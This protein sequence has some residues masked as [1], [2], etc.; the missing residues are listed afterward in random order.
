[1]KDIL[2]TTSSNSSIVEKLLPF[3]RDV[4]ALLKQLRNEILFYTDLLRSIVSQEKESI[5]QLL[6]DLTTT[7]R[8]YSPD[9]VRVVPSQE[10]LQSNPL[11][12]A[13]VQAQTAMAEKV[14]QS[15]QNK[16]KLI[17]VL[18]SECKTVL[19]ALS[20][21]VDAQQKKELKDLLTNGSNAVPI[22][23]NESRVMLGEFFRR[24]KDRKML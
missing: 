3:H 11:N 22:K 16:K 6:A 18:P 20:P 4:E 14:V 2:I 8:Q 23:F 1:M 12:A 17:T 5:Q 7:I 15:P 21:Y 19:N 9:G 13:L 24:L 10:S